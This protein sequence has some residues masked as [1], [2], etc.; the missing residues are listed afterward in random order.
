MCKPRA[1]V[2][3]FA[4][5]PQYLLTSHLP[6][7]RLVRIAVEA[8][9]RFLQMIFEL[10]RSLAFPSGLENLFAFT[11]RPSY[12]DRWDLFDPAR[13]YERIGLIGAGER[14]TERTPPTRPPP[15][16]TPQH[17]PPPPTRTPRHV[18]PS[19]R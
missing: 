9:T 18:D 5:A 12:P 19:R 6:Y 4:T 7:P 15:T 2:R 1:A 3:S 10:I 17:E 13:E 8:E 11:Y 16:R 14:E